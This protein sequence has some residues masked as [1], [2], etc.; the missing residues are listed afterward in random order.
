MLYFL[1]F[2]QFVYSANKEMED[3]KRSFEADITVL[4]GQLKKAE[5]NNN[6]LEKRLEQKVG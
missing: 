6:C 4:K 2:K 1:F 5:M 3:T